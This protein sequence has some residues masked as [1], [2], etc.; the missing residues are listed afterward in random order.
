[1]SASALNPL[2]LT[3]LLCAATVLAAGAGIALRERFSRVGWLHLSLSA[4]IAGWQACMG[5]ALLSQDSDALQQW[6]RLVSFFALTIV[7][8][9]HQFGCAITGEGNRG[10]RALLWIATAALL[11]CHAAGALQT[12]VLHY[13]WG[14]YLAY[15][16]AGGIFAALTLLVVGVIQHKYWRMLSANRP[17]S[18]AA[19]RARLL[20]IALGVGMLGAIDFLPAFGMDVLPLGGVGVA[21][22]NLLHAWATWR[23]RLVEIAPAYVAE[24]L[25]DSMGEGVVMIDRDG[26]VRLANPA[27]AELL[28]IERGSLLNR[29]PPPG[30]AKEVL[31]WQHSP[32]F[33]ESDMALGERQYT[34]PDGTHRVLD[35]G[36]VL[37]RDHGAEPG[38][39]VISLHDITATVQAQEQIER[40]AYYDPLTHLPNRALLRERFGEAIARARRNEALAALLF[41][42]LD[43][44]KHVNDDLGHDAGDLLLKSVAERLSACVRETDWLLRGTE[45]GPG[46]LL[47]RLGGDEFVVVLSPLERPEDA[48]RIATRI[49]EALARPFAL[50]RGAEVTSGASIGIS[51]Y[52]HDGD[53]T[54]TLMKKA[55]L[56]MYQAKESGRN[57]FRFHDEA[58]NAAAL[59]RTDL[60]N[61]LRRGLLRSEFLLLYQ[62]QIDSVSGAIAGLD[63]QIYWRHPEHGLVPAAEFVAASEDSSVVLPLTEWIVRSACLQLRAWCALGAQPLYLSLNLPPGAA[64]RGKLPRLVREALT[65]AGIDPGLVMVSLRGAP[66]VREGERT[67]EAMQT[68]QSMGLRLVLDELGSGHSRL[69]NL[70]QYPLSMVRFE[71]AFLRGLARDGDLAAVTRALIN[72]VHS[73]HLGVLVTGLEN[74]G[75]AALLRELGC[76][77]VQGPAF[78]MPVPADQVPG[79]LSHTSERAEAH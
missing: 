72:L 58:M 55:D 64:E 13:H 52:P 56:A 3:M 38:A 40:L 44:F 17:G 21:A 14:P 60:E 33:P 9:L 11:A 47:A 73:L 20:M 67:R 1:M 41:L 12:G 79:L 34:A 63:A 59:A 8:V 76:D 77:I 62:P 6:L 15:G 23:Y 65:L 4:A 39:A 68:L 5:M 27:A 29:L 43:R 53:D 7:P 24:Q 37:M 16:P 51:V 46:S 54:E 78:G 48:A 28:G 49:L 61:G 69:A 36:V 19:R 45:L 66:G 30:L 70:H 50:K 35:V 18:I 2:A 22:G 57:M 31:G 10:G 75:Q 32:F 74:S 26:V 71:L 42:D 25:M